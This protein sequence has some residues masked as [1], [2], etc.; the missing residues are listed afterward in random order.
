MDAALKRQVWQ[1]AGHCCEY[2]RM[3]QEYDDTPFEIDH[4]I[5]RKHGGPT[6]AGNL[7]LSCF[8][9]NSFKGSNLGG[10]DPQT[11]KLTPLF[12]PR[13]HTWTRHFRWQGPYLIGRT[14]LGRVTVAVLNINDPF[15]VELREGLIE[16]GLFPPP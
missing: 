11:R 3:P 7:A 5:A 8:F 2:C 6:V 12:N 9:C 13:R 16:E 15:R 1:R 4:I 14:P 10:L